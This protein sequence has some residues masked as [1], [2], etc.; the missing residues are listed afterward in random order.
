[1]KRRKWSPEEWRAWRARSEAT[2]RM[3][4]DRIERIEAELGVKR[5]ADEPPPPRFED[6][7]RW[8]PEERRR[9]EAARETMQ[10]TLREHI[11]RITAELEAKR[12][13]A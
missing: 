1:M 3:L 13:P 5:P 9:W 4:R 6:R 11:E 8:T 10:R 2:E 7:K 12:R